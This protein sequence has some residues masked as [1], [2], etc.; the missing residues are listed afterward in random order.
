[1]IG[2]QAHVA[3]IKCISALVLNVSCLGSL[4]CV[5]VCLVS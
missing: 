2:L 1:M 4:L 5:C 3:G